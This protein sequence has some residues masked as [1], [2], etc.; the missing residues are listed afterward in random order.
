MPLT[1]ECKEAGRLE[2]VIDSSRCEGKAD[3]ARVCPYDVFVVQKLS[4]EQRAGL[5]L[6]TRFKVMVHGGKQG[7]VTRAADCR[8]CGLCVSACPEKAIRLRAAR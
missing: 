1:P 2:P 3:C 6:L 7:F 5:G 4:A 8:G